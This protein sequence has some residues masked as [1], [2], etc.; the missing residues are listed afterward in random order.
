MIK[1][2]EKPVDFV[3]ERYYGATEI[4]D[5]MRSGKRTDEMESSCLAALDSLL[6]A[7]DVHVAGAVPH[8]R[9]TGEYAAYLSRL[10]GLDEKEAD[11]IKRCA[12]FHDIG[13]IGIPDSIFQKPGRLTPEEMEIMEKHTKIGY[14]LLRHFYFMREEAETAYC[15][16]ERPDGKG[17]PRGLSGK[18]IP[19]YARIVLVA[20]AFD[21]MRSDRVYRPALSLKATIREITEGAG[22]QFDSEVVKI[23]KNCYKE[24]DTLLNRTNATALP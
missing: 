15:H 17:Y 20:D 4:L 7:L 19:L 24:L 9:R 11:V 13:K 2:I 12:V 6:I 8:A 23:F 14:D 22:T 3:T 1:H 18:D 5:I 21:A 10:M 16:H